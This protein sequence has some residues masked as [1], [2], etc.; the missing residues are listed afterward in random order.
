MVHR[1]SKQSRR[2]G[3]KSSRPQ[4]VIILG[5]GIS[6][7]A[8]AWYLHKAG[9]PFKLYEKKA[10]TGGV[11]S[12]A[13][14]QEAVLDFGPNSLRDRTGDLRELAD[15]V[16]ISEDIIE[17]S[18]AFKTRFIV[19][20]GALQQLAPSLMSMVS[21][22]ILSAKAKWRLL[23]EPFIPKKTTDNETVG[24]FLERR[25]G[26]EAVHYLADP[27]F[28]GIYAGDVYRMSAKE[29][30]PKLVDFEQNYG[31]IAW[32]ALR[33]EKEK[34]KVKPRV[35][36]FR[37]GIQQVT[38][39][40]SD[41]LSE[42]I[43]HEEVLSVQKNELGY[44]VKTA[45]EAAQAHAVI[46][47][48]PAYS[49]A[50]VLEGFDPKYSAILS[51]IEYAPVL[52]T[53]IIFDKAKADFAQQGFG[54]L[55]PRKEGIRLLGAIWK[56][57]IFPELTSADN[58]H[59]ALL[60]GGAH[61]REVLSEPVEKVEEQVITAFKKITG[62]TAAPELVRSK[63]WD[64]AIPQFNTGYGEIRKQFS[65]LEK[66]NPGFYVGGNYRWGAAVPDCIQGAK[67]LAQVIQNK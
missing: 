62:I 18:E 33:T 23:A 52:S 53:Q 25:I 39:A 22:P 56:S 21:T 37:K 38:D 59:F 36:T 65:A 9:I 7:L 19:R 51:R 3:L 11:I 4:E 35:V 47:C 32:G 12:S 10:G 48:I 17:I 63:L 58:I 44:S 45:Q 34:K 26:K 5:G 54:F 16:G 55:V 27:I 50:A 40:I 41:R 20:N 49:L 64:K 46:S 43:I 2:S 13:L 29:I 31:S 14:V 8:T 15:E 42:H 67:V 57:S 61:D 60:T 6:G 66:E 1:K 28:S 24:A 30:M